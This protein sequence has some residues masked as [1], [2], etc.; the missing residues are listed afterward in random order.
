MKLYATGKMSK[1]QYVGAS[2]AIDEMLERLKSEQELAA[3]T[4]RGATPNTVSMS[5]L[6][7]FCATARSRFESCADFEAKRRFLREYVG[8]V[9]FNKG[10][11]TVIGS[12][13]AHG[14][15]ASPWMQLRSFSG[16]SRVSR[17]SSTILA[18][19]ICVETIELWHGATTAGSCA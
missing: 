2:R 9:V 18:S 5:R 6:R 4:K 1:M 11:V 19:R 17:M 3:R 15:F 14:G 16:W 8:R 7:Q 13:P 12:I 10:R